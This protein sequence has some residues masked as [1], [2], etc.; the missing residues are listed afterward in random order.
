[1][2]GDDFEFS[3]IAAALDFVSVAVT[4]RA[5]HG[6]RAGGDEFVDVLAMAVEGDAVALGL[7][8]VQKIPADGGQADG[9]RGSSAGIGDRHLLCG[10]VKNAEGQG[11][12]NE[13]SDKLCHDAS[14]NLGEGY[15]KSTA[16]RDCQRNNPPECF[17]PRADCFVTLSGTPSS[18]VV[19]NPLRTKHDQCR[20]AV[21][22]GN[23]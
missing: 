12:E 23:D 8:D 4:A 13:Y 14:V 11:D 10:E 22:D 5:R 20:C 19:L 2:T 15:G 6:E 17:G 3:G 21:R 1:M 7:R 18:P 9:L 16:V